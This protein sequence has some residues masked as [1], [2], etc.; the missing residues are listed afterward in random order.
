MV[1]WM[2]GLSGAG[3]TTLTDALLKRFKPAL[4]HLVRL[5]GD[6]IRALFGQSLSYR[7]DDRV[8]QI[9]RIQ[10]MAS[11]LDAQGLIV[12]VAALYAHPDLLRWNRENFSD[13]F[14]VYLDAPLELVQERDAKGLY[15]KARK[16]E[17][18]HVVGI[19]VPWHAPENAD[20]V[21]DATRGDT[22]DQIAATIARRIP[23]LSSVMDSVE[24]KDDVA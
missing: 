18:P 9:N 10:K 15:E 17:M 23:A 22:P 13:Y 8:E 7:E 2:T 16:G 24:L 11:I 1:I 12:L 14:E 4:P 6:E 21:V 5:D 3:K 20:L 19:D